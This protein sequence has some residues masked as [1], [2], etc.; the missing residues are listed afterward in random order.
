MLTKNTPSETLL[1]VSNFYFICILEVVY[2]DYFAM[3]PHCAFTVFKC[4]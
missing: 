4:L 2:F 1:Q 3:K